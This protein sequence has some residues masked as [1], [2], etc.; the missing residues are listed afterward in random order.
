[1]GEGLYPGV[2]VRVACTIEPETYFVREAA[3]S[4]RLIEFEMLKS[5]AG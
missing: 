2:D 1:V 4:T 5:V 3:A